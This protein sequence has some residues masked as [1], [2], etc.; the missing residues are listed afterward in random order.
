[1]LW[2]VARIVNVLV[3]IPNQSAYR[4]LHAASSTKT[5]AADRLNLYSWFPFEF[6]TCGDSQEVYLIDEWLFEN[7]GL[8]SKNAHLFPTKVPRNFMGCSLNVGVI[9]ISPNVIMTENNTHNNGSTEYRLTGGAV[10]ILKSIVEKMNLTACFLPPMLKFELETGMKMAAELD[11]GLSDILIGAIPLTPIVVTSSFEATI[12]YFQF[13]IK[14]LVPCP[15]SIHASEKILTTFSLSVW[16]TIGLVQLLTTAVFWCA[17]NGPYRSVGTETHTY[18]TLSNSF[19]NAWAVFMGVS[20]PRQPTASS[21]RVFFFLYVCFCFAIST[22]FQAF[23]VSYLVEP[24]YEKQ[25]ETLDDLLH[26]DIVYGYHPAI[27]Q[28]QD[29]LSFPEFVKFLEH[30]KLQ[31]DCSDIRKCVERMVTQKGIAAVMS[32]LYVTYVAMEMGTVDVGKVV[33][34]LHEVGASTGLIF[35]FKKGNPLLDRFNILMRRYLEAGLM[36]NVV[37]EL[38]H[39]A[40]LKGAGRF[41]EAA[42]NQFFPFSVSHLMPAF[43]AFIVGTV[44]S[45]VVFIGE[46][47]VNCLC[48]SLKKL[49]GVRR[50]R[51]LY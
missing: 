18:Q 28:F 13:D 25:L 44:F 15:K 1:V 26:S 41:G 21:L 30:K 9:G 40:S 17:G 48:K 45:S 29:T 50:L 37:T 39:L 31:E 8:F 35:L 3:L 51:N 20:V 33:C 34:S 14:M 7:K 24:K 46:L 27:N 23:F 19:Q 16:L 6:G 38:L 42:G 10:E 4:P 22:V 36:E 5:T 49:S 32:P 2:Q 47:I 12:P 43:V 11:E